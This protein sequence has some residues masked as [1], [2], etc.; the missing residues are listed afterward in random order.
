MATKT[1]GARPTVE[2]EL[3]EAEQVGC[4]IVGV[5]EAGRGP[6]AG[7]VVAA[8]VAF[9]IPDLKGVK[10]DILEQLNDS[11]AVSEVVREELY[12]AI[13]PAFDWGIGI[14]DVGRID[15]CNILNATM[16]AMR[17]AVA[18]LQQLPASALIDGNRDPGLSCRTRTV[19]KG[20]ARCLSIAAASIV[21]KVTRDRIMRDI[22]ERYPA[23]G[24]AK[25]K[26][27]GTKEHLEAIQRWGV[28]PHHRR[29]F[30]PVR[31]ALAD[32]A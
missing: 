6:L 10:G 2:I 7:P 21:A 11:K 31:S 25:H 28:T 12:E 26:G 8:A 30:S 1:R 16:W 18:G 5:D 32:E 20:D 22:A 3:Q 29:S 9:T 23:Y 24:F 19:V 17:Q 13:V 4:P 15:R 27:Y 14:A